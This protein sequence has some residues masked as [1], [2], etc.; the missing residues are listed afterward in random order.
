M[1]GWGWVVIIASL[2]EILLC[3]GRCLYLQILGGWGGIYPDEI[4]FCRLLIEPSLLSGVSIN[5][6]CVLNVRL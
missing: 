4:V 2:Y 5:I 1:G 3:T 6:F